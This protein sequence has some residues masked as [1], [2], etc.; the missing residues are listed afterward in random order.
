MD[1]SAPSASAGW[2]RRADAGDRLIRALRFTG[3]NDR[4]L[5]VAL[6]ATDSNVAN[7]V[8]WFDAASASFAESIAGPSWFMDVV[9][10]EGS[11]AVLIATGGQAVVCQRSDGVCREYCTF[12]NGSASELSADDG[13]NMIAG[14]FLQGPEPLHVLD[15]DSSRTTAFPDPPGSVF[16]RMSPRL[17]MSQSGARVAFSFGFGATSVWN[18]ADRSALTIP[19]PDSSNIITNG[20]PG[21]AAQVQ[22]FLPMSGAMARRIWLSDDDSLLAVAGMIPY[23]SM[24]PFMCVWLVRLD[25]E[26]PAGLLN[27]DSTMAG[28]DLTADFALCVASAGQERDRLAIWDVAAATRL[29]DFDAGVHDVTDV[30]IDES[31]SY[32]AVAGHSQLCL[33]RFSAKRWNNESGDANGFWMLQLNGNRAFAPVGMSDFESRF[34]DAMRDTPPHWEDAVA[35]AT[36]LSRG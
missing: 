28:V 17:A 19:R 33:H 11:D 30:R 26:G 5:V 2:P 7:E 23:R 21:L 9:P 20:P 14:A 22:E 25:A 18:V 15:F 31:V 8:A 35:V 24:A 13:A 29:V 12:G 1:R 3:A 6:G 34:T 16:A 36:A 4:M 27:L 10:L 32:I